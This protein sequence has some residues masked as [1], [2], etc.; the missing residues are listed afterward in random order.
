MAGLGALISA[1]NE[2][3]T[4]WREQR[5]NDRKMA[6]ELRDVGVVSVLQSPDLYE[7]YLTLQGDNPQYSAG[8]IVLCQFQLQEPTIIGTE[9][10]WRQDGRRILESERENSAKIFVR[11]KN[12]NINGYTLGA[13]YDISQTSGRDIERLK[14]H[15]HT[16]QMEKAVAALLN[17][18]NVEIVPD[19]KLTD[20]PALYDENTIKL[21]VNPDAEF[22]DAFPVL[23]TEIQLA[24]QHKKGYNRNFNREI[25][26]L[27]ADSVSYMICRRYGIERDLP[28]TSGIG[29]IYG[30]ATVSQATE[31]LNYLQNEAKYIGGSIEQQIAPPQRAQ[32]HLPTRPRR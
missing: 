31:T 1:K 13:A 28:D 27:A 30:G 14:I 11:P 10:K 16:A 26:Y 3:D 7:Q 8:N 22:K 15:P 2:S 12:R 29:A 6:D 18:S 17:F 5:E 4:K 23:A 9:E 19:A 21:Y 32:A 24:R 25:C 20:T